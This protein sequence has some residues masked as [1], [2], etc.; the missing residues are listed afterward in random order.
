MTNPFEELQG[1]LTR[2]ESYLL[3]LLRQQNAAT[4]ERAQ[5]ERPISIKEAAKILSLSVGAIYQNPDIPR[6][7]RNNKLR[8]FESELL[9]YIKNKD[10]V[11]APPP[12][13]YIPRKRRA[14]G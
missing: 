14:K 5:A 7:K 3:Q 13:P 9:N 2:I 11:E 8:F 6:H 12:E 10:Q 1:Q 4:T